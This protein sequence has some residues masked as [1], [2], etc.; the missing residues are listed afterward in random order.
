M[1]ISFVA[2]PT[3]QVFLSMDLRRKHGRDIDGALPGTGPLSCAP[4][5]ATIR[6]F[7]PAA[8]V[9]G[10]RAPPPLDLQPS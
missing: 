10:S 1:D 8:A 3:K 9:V 7:C 2:V 6:T 5:S 4:G